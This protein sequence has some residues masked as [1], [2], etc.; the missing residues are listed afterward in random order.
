M[1]LLLWCSFIIRLA[2]CELS[3]YLTFNTSVNYISYTPFSRKKFCKLQLEKFSFPL[4][5]PEVIF[6]LD[7]RQ[8]GQVDFFFQKILL[9]K[10]M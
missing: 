6:G 5:Y 10:W 2:Y 9:W 4:S 3:F 7:K 1:V 8:S